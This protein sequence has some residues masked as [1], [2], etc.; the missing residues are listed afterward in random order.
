MSWRDDNPGGS[1]GQSYGG[2]SMDEIAVKIQEK[3]VRWG[4]KGKDRRDRGKRRP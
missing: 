2:P 1:G 3:I 4:G